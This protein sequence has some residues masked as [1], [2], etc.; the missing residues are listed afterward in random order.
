[1]N[2][3]EGVRLQKILSEAGLASR[4]EAESMIRDGEVTINGRVAQLGD[5]ALPGKDHIKVRGKLLRVMPS[6]VVIAFF[7][8]RGVSATVSDPHNL[9]GTIW[10]YL[11]RAKEKVF[12][13]GK[14]DKDTEGLLLLTN[15]GELSERLTKAKFE[16]PKVYTV[17]IDGHLEDKKQRRLKA[18]VAVENSKVRVADLVPMRGSEG[19]QWLR[20]TL[21][22]PR[23]RLIR[24]IFEAVGHPVDKVRRE[25]MAGVTLKGLERGEWRYLSEKE[26]SD[27]RKFVGLNNEGSLK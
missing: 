17:K 18:G 4:R 16:V 13:V 10:E 20:V 19:K 24:K 1:M 27:L 14:L 8:P 23:N 26:I 6:K 7:K 25:S 3:T 12:P 5:K 2:A 9:G 11:G 15:D 22:E 21:T